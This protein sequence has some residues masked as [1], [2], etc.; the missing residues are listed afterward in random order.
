MKRRT[1]A[2]GQ[3]LGAGR[4]SGCEEVYRSGRSSARDARVKLVRSR[5]G[6]LC[7]CVQN[8]GLGT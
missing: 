3:R 4:L 6:I 8:G 2:V 7:V 5:D 1:D